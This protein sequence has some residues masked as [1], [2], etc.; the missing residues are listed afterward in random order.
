[1]HLP[2]VLFSVPAAAKYGVDPEAVVEVG[3]GS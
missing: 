3:A 2:A 1:M